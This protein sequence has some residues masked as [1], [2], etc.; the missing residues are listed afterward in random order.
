MLSTFP[1]GVG[2]GKVKAKKPRQELEAMIWDRC[3][4]AGMN[5]QS[6]TVSPS[7]TNGW[8]ANYIAAPSLVTTYTAEFDRIVTELRVSFDLA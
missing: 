1:P 7:K 2:P 5:L 6:V 4:E 3:L 8:E